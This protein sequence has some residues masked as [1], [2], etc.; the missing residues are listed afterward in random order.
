[1][2][3]PDSAPLGRRS[4]LIQQETKAYTCSIV[5]TPSAR[6]KLQ[7]VSEG[8]LMRIR[9]NERTAKYEHQHQY[10]GP[11]RSRKDIASAQGYVRRYMLRETEDIQTPTPQFISFKVSQITKDVLPRGHSQAQIRQPEFHMQALRTD[12]SQIEL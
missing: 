1:M 10:R 12:S 9:V 4:T 5:R 7:K 8:P 6:S 3:I 2:T 11:R